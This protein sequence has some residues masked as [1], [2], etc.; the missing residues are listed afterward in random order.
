MKILWTREVRPT[1]VK[2]VTW[3]TSVGFMAVSV[4][5]TLAGQTL[6][7]YCLLYI[8]WALLAIGCVVVKL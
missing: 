7:G 8:A 2:M 4:L 3:L 6:L 5:S 1:P